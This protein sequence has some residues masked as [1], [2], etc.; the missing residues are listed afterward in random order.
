MNNE[1][2]E[3]ARDTI[4][5]IEPADIGYQNL[6]C[7]ADDDWKDKV[8]HVGYPG[9]KNLPKT[10]NKIK[11]MEFKTLYIAVPDLECEPWHQELCK[12]KTATWFAAEPKK[13]NFWVDSTGR[14]IH[15]SMVTWWF[16][17]IVAE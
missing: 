15:E 9:I 17:K 10:V 2:I 6:K 1:V 16:I 4:G 5:D 3:Q 11:E 7:N 13:L 8:I 14:K 12:I